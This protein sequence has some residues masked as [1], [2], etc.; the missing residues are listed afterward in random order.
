MPGVK[1]L[2]N[3]IEKKK[4]QTSSEITPIKGKITS[5]IIEEEDKKLD[6][7]V[8]NSPKQDSER[9]NHKSKKLEK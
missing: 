7:V 5:Q 8:M 2:P 9:G 6:E 3:I 4:F 1:F